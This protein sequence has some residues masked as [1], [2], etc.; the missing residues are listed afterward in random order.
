MPYVHGDHQ[1]GDLHFHS[2]ISYQ[3]GAENLF[4]SLHIQY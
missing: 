2:E 1:K 4:V 3:L